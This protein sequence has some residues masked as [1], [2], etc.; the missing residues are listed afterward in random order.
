MFILFFVDVGSVEASGADLFVG[1]LPP[2]LYTLKVLIVLML[3]MLL[4]LMLVLLVVFL[5]MLL[6]FVSM[7]LLSL[8]FC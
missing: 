6:V 4:M 2:F 8:F 5:L 7:L 3:L 1:C